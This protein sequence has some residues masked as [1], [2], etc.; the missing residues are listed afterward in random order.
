MVRAGGV[1]RAV[2]CE[3]VVG[4]ALCEAVRGDINGAS[5]RLK[6][7]LDGAPV[8]VE[9][10]ADA[11]LG[12]VVLGVRARLMV[13]A[14]LADEAFDEHLR[15]LEQGFAGIDAEASRALVLESMAEAA[16]GVDVS[17][18]APEV[19]FARGVH[20]ARDPSK[21]SLAI[22]RLMVVAERADAGAL[23]APA[24]WE[25]AV[26]QL[27]G[28]TEDVARAV[29][30]LTR[31]ARSFPEAEQAPRALEA[32]LAYGQRLASDGAGERA[33]EG[34]LDAVSEGT[35]EITDRSFWLIER[36]KRALR[37]LRLDDAL[38]TLELVAP[39]DERA[40]EASTLFGA[41]AREG[42]DAAWIR[43]VEARASGRD[44][45]TMAEREIVPLASRAVV[46]ARDRDLTWVSQMRADLADARTEAGQAGSRVLYQRLMD[47]GVTVPGGEVRLRLGLARSL[48]IAR[49]RERAFG[50]LREV[51]ELLGDVPPADAR[52]HERFW[53]T[54]T[55]ILELLAEENA[56]GSRTG[57]ILAH[58]VRL[59][60]IDPELGGAV[61]RARIEAVRASAS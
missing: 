12:I 20:L 6:R 17:S 13:N 14:G 2:W 32:A 33:Y 49:E 44:V 8:I 43:L 15:I 28:D 40:P 24:L 10:R 48:L 27:Q 26:L 47:E 37:E 51:A 11:A 5:G 35:V 60:T 55:L 58:I 61:W 30:S 22:E 25:A 3:A 29:G 46:Y 59:E 38:S 16:A 57:V 34:A 41:A 9:G 31:L 36:A 4:M 19:G 42:I 18:L 54:W 56:D 39:N 53:L 50:R 7:A 1:P 45:T 23:A 21:R 52:G